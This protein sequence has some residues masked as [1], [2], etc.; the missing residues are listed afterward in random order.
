MKRALVGIA[1]R[2]FVG[3]LGRFRIFLACLG[4]GAFAIASSGSITESFRTGVNDQARLL[5]GGDVA[6]TAA[7]RLA[8]SDQRAFLD[9][10]GVVSETA[11]LRLMAESA[12]ARKQVDVRAVDSAYPLLGEIVLSGGATTP[13]AALAQTDGR[14]GVAV[15]RSFL[16]TFSLAVGDEA[17]IGTMPVR[18]TAVLERE[19]DRIGQ[20][21][22]I[23]PSALI[24]IDAPKGAGRLET[25]QLFRA[26]YLLR[27]PETPSYLRLE[28][29]S[30]T[31][32]GEDGL[33]MRQPEDAVDGL[34]EL[35]SLL[36]AFF[37]VVGVASLVAGGVGIS[38]ATSAFLESR[39]GSI[40]ALKAFGAS[41]GD[42][43]IIYLLQLAG[44]ALLGAGAGVALGALAPFA[45]AAF[46]GDR[47]PLP[48][49]PALYPGPLL[50]AV[51]LSLLTAAAF[52]LPALG[53]ARATPPAALFRRLEP[54]AFSLKGQPELIAAI[55]AAIALVAVAT[56]ASPRPQMTALLLL[57]AVVAYGLLVGA[58]LVIKRLARRAAKT[59]RG[60]N[61]LMLSNLG[62]PGSLAP[63]VAPALGLGLSVLTLV[64]VV[65]AN[66][67]RQ[68]SETAPASAPSLVFSQ[69]PSREAERFD[70][71]LKDKGVDV[72]SAEAFRRIPVLLGRV[73]ALRGKP[74]VETDVTEGERWVV[75]REIQI[76]Y[77]ADMPEETEL[78]EGK[79]W[80]T[81]YAGEPLVSVEQGVATGMALKVGDVMGFRVFGR[82]FDARVA[83]IRRVDWGGFG[84]NM[85]FVFS[86]G[87]LSGANPMN[88]AIARV[89]VEL[90][91][92]I[93]DAIAPA[94]P[95][96]VVFQTRE[97]LA[98]ATKVVGDISIAVNA[99]ASV[100]TLAGLLVLA[101]A[102][103]TIVR[104]RRMESA[105]LKT[106]GAT[107]GGLLA[108]Y[109]G[110]F[111][112]AGAAAT[113][114]GVG[115]GILA[116]WPVVILVFE[117]KWTFPWGAIAV[118]AGLAIGAS[119]L[120]GGLVGRSLMSER[121]WR[122]LSTS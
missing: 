64:A 75:G 77:L 111:A 85:P 37:S 102:L 86:P 73:T 87:A 11:N 41:A 4:I 69:I 113:L 49:V 34:G 23:S 98:T 61:R 74:L 39:V 70:Q 71:I 88:F 116:A 33:R 108:L 42:I 100:V 57:A 52:A 97:A 48:Q 9:R 106:I 17:M 115:L 83:S 78:T 13:A 65:Q 30:K 91:K 29:D 5:L 16:E 89:P 36:N 43:R 80:A 15:S 31:A 44:L 62:G 51:V 122:I 103:A 50:L 90:E 99:I 26:T 56:V 28:A 2:E 10:I 27:T 18:V 63:L 60:T 1:W 104:K 8:T 59:A 68:I 24:S 66:L 92:P 19:P 12:S 72:S 119:A 58:A 82:T 53:R 7:Q 105:L 109:A 121:P 117:A 14:W 114:I 21:G 110:E 54:A 32:L 35:L 38:Q 81:D 118:I 20:P 93:I 40:A 107:R 95:D 96:V 112:F 76:T 94:F 101:G 25:G 45:L 67:L 55:A 120:G 6:F 46:A 84:V 3:G 47:I 79:W 22:V